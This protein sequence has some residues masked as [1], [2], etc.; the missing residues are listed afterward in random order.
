MIAFISR[1]IDFRNTPEGEAPNPT[2]GVINNKMGS[3]GVN[4]QNQKRKSDGKLGNRNDVDEIEK[5]HRAY[6]S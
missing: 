1:S 6:P 5:E 2:K 3:K 4:S